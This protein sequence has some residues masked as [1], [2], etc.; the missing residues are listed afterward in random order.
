M[1]QQSMDHQTWEDQFHRVH[2]GHGHDC[3]HST[4][5]GR[6]GKYGTCAADTLWLSETTKNNFEIFCL[7]TVKIHTKNIWNTKEQVWNIFLGLPGA[8]KTHKNIK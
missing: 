4:A 3:R 1:Y 5:V 2:A 7:E 6:W 8:I